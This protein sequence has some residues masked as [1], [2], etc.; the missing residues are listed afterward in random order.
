MGFSESARLEAV[1]AFAESR[2]APKVDSPL[3]ERKLDLTG[4][5]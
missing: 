1:N 5:A 4:Y 2:N 3:I